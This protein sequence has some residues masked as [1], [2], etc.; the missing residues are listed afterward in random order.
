MLDLAVELPRV[1]AHPV[2]ILLARPGIDDE[3]VFVFAETMHD[4]V[5]NKRA[6]GIK[7]SG[8]LRLP[9]RQTTRVV[10]GN[11]LDG[12]QRLRSRE[13]DVTHVADVED[14]DAGA[15]RVV[16][17]HDAAGGRVFD[18]HVP[19]IEFNHLGAHLAVDGVQRGL[20]DGRRSRLNGRQAEPS[21]RC[22]VGWA[23]ESWNS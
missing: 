17:G 12:R 7:K 23:A 21:I 9:D 22:A 19:A 11:V 16:L 18:G 3:Q 15:H 13:A 2:E 14:A 8:V 1:I 10:H 6:L 20:A 4:D 5:V